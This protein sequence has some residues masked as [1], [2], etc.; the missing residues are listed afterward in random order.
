M[1]GTAAGAAVM[2]T[3]FGERLRELREAKGVTA[4]RLAQLAGVSRQTL[5]SIEVGRAD[6]SWDTAIRVARA[7][8]ISLDELAGDDVELPS[9]EEP[10]KAG[11]PRKE[12]ERKPPAKKRRGKK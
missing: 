12:A 5:S 2:P 4:Y 8:G 10:K 6:P 3:R 7:L 11:R 1:L 9:A